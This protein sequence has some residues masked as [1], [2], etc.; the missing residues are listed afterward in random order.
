MKNIPGKFWLSL[1]IFIAVVDGILIAESL[2]SGEQEEVL[3]DAVLEEEIA[4]IADEI[5]EAPI[6]EPEEPAAPAEPAQPETRII[7]DVPFTTQAPYKWISPW[8]EY[9]EE[10]CVYMAMAWVRGSE[11]GD[12]RKRSN[13]LVTIGEWENENIGGSG[14]TTVIQTLQILTGYYLWERAYLS[15][16]PSVEYMVNEIENG[17]V[18][19]LPINGQILDSPYYSD[20]APAH[21]NLLIVGV[22]K[23]TQVFIVHDPGTIRGANLEISYEKILESNQDLDGEQIAVIIQP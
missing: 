23:E 20:P 12:F 10:A 7:H 16:D 17:H 4:E 8:T 6:E 14:D 19:I 22:D 15:L 3:Y 13:D 18:I 9:A 1:F 21:H 2:L 11:L 5:L